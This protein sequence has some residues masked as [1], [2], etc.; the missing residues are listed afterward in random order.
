[1]PLH[2]ANLYLFTRIP[3]TPSV[4]PG[5]KSSTSPLRPPLVVITRKIIVASV[6]PYLVHKS[7]KYT[8]FRHTISLVVPLLI[9]FD[10][11]QVFLF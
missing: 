4:R 11:F 6:N 7:E 2:L 1:M 5:N 8:S 9:V 10:N 3:C